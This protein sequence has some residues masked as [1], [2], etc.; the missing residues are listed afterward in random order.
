MPILQPKYA[1]RFQ[2]VYIFW[3]HPT[4]DFYIRDNDTSTNKLMVLFKTSINTLNDRLIN[5]TVMLEN[6][7]SFGDIPY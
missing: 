2:V 3:H 5:N 4:E 7:E 6:I 1:N